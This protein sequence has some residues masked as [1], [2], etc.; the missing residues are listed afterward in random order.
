[1]PRTFAMGG[2][3]GKPLVGYSKPPKKSPWWWYQFGLSLPS[4]LR[5]K[6]Y[7]ITGTTSGTGRA[8][9][10][11]LAERS[12]RIICL[13]RPTERAVEALEAIKTHGAEFCAKVEHVD[14]DLASFDSVKRAIAKVKK[15]C[16][17]SGIDVLCCN[18]GIMA[19]HDEAT[20]D[21]YDSQMQV[22]QLSHFLLAKELMPLLEKAAEQRH[23]SRIVMHSSSARFH[24]FNLGGKLGA[25][26]FGKNGG[27]LGG[28]GGA[29]WQ[30]Y[31]QTKLANAV[32]TAEL[33]R[34]LRAKG[35][36]VMALAAAPGF[37]A[38]NLQV[39]THN[40][41]GMPMGGLMS[42]V[43]MMLVGQSPEDGAMPLL[44]AMLDNRL[45]SGSFMEPKNMA[46]GVPVLKQLKGGCGSEANGKLLWE[47]CE[48]A[49]G[50][51]KL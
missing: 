49:V 8:A 43:G 21:G 13:N 16:A 11:A 7:V 28:D 24:P 19:I 26:Y 36:K 23:R 33:D 41:G 4:D 48:K 51:F 18:A 9:A 38:T 50:A 45:A 44:M 39:T 22:N 34:R 14:C 10:M 32:F 1:M 20:K 12:A 46:W 17:D 25:K 29:R 6:T 31:H 42:A 40:D 3:N 2:V 37:A 47:E 30:R 15:A 35:S 27:N 5:A